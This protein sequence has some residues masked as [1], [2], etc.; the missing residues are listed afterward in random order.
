ML[1]SDSC[2]EYLSRHSAIFTRVDVE[3]GFQVQGTRMPVFDPICNQELAKF[4]SASNVYF[5]RMRGVSR[6]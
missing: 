1:I 5:V 3:D 2:L 4:E 6:K